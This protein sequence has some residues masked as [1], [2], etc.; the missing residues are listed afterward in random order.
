MSPRWKLCRDV[1][2]GTEAVREEDNL[3]DYLPQGPAETSDQRLRRSKRA[4]FFPMF[5]ETVKGLTGLVFRKDP[6]FGDD[7]PPPIVNLLE[8]IDG[9]GTHVAIFAKRL[10]ADGLKKGHGGILVDVPKVSSTRP[11]TI[12]EEKTIGLRPY[13]VWIKP[14]QITNWRYQTINGHLVL[15][16]LVLAEVI[17]VPNGNY[18]TT[19]ATRYR[20]FSRDPSGLIKY[21]VWTQTAPDKDPEIFDNGTLKNVNVIPFTAFYAGERV[22]PLQSIPPLI[23]LAYTNIAHWQVLCD[24]RTAVHAAGNAILVI[25]GRTTSGVSADPNLPL[26]AQ[27]TNPDYATEGPA[28]GALAPT[29]DI[30]LGPEMGIEVDKDGAVEF[31]EVSGNAIGATRQEIVDIETRGAAQGLAM[32]QR[33]TRAAQTAE[34]E[35]LQRNEK[36]ASLSSAARSLEDCIEMA[37]AY[38]ALFM[39]LETGGSCTIDRA[40]EETEIDTP[41][42][43]VLSAATAL[44]QFTRRTFWTMMIRGGILP[45]DFNMDAEEAALNA[46]TAITLDASTNT[47]SGGGGAG[48]GGGQKPPTST[49]SGDT[50]A[51]S[52]QRAA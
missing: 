52:G 5:K 28:A 22:A 34:T 41:R 47:D 35:K 49:A 13:W 37:L 27:V 30:V 40:F 31:A 6:V 46:A 48:S 3:D 44:G 17:D 51:G 18:G 20:V 33:S 2:T 36:D 11:L 14:E 12:Q 9:A 43:Q 24:Q 19:T 8:N 21:E 38:T 26:S 39:G 50:G 10:F 1:D 25:K 29:S 23:D 7:V 4:E 32:L 42:I 15:T 45:D 16:L